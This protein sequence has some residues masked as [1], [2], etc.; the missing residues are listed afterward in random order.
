MKFSGDKSM[1]EH[2]EIARNSLS[3][4]CAFFSESVSSCHRFSIDCFSAEQGSTLNSFKNGVMRDT[5]ISNSI[6]ECLIIA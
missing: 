3:A 5:D 1:W 2:R 4:E 6:V